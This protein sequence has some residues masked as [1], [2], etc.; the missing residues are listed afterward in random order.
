MAE[1]KMNC[2]IVSSETPWHII[3]HS[4]KPFLV[5]FFV[6]I[7]LNCLTKRGWLGPYNSLIPATFDW[8]G[9]TKPG[10]WVIMYM[11]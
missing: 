9:C 1:Y 4:N 11:C 10:K 5:L 2:V 7:M 8:S 3:I 6:S